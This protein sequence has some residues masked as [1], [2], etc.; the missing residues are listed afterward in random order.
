[1]YRSTEKP[2]TEKPPTKSAL[3]SIAESS[4]H[5]WGTFG[6][7][8]GCYLHMPCR[9]GFSNQIW[10]HLQPSCRL[11]RKRLRGSNGSLD[12]RP[13]GPVLS[14]LEWKEFEP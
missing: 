9:V 13:E 3:R 11:E 7:D 4:E 14:I 6:P 2:Q 1:M 12:F 8:Q 10:G 5:S